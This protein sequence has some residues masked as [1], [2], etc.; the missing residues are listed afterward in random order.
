MKRIKGKTSRLK[1][2]FSEEIW[3]ME[4][5]ELSKAKARFIKYVKVAI[6]TAKTYAQQKIGPQ[7]VALSYL[8]VMALVPFLAIVFAITGGL[9]FDGLLKDFMYENF[10]SNQ[11][12]IDTVLSFSQNIIDTAQSGWMGF[13]NALLFLWIIY[14]LMAGVESA[15]N[16]VWKVNSNRSLV[17][18]LSYYLLILILSPFVILVLFSG[19]FVYT[20]LL[21]Y[22]GL[23]II[24][25]SFI[26][27]VISWLLFIVVAALTFSAMYK[28]I[29]KF[30]VKYGVAFRAAVFAAVAF[31]GMQ[32][33]YL[34]TQLL[35][36]RLNGVY[37]TFA[38]I[39]L[40]MV[41]LNISWNI[42]LMGAELSYAFQHVD[43]YNL[44]D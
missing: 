36:T 5:E 28:F 44:E 34:E 30:N 9:G 37:G 42:I 22:M 33:L 29:P 25:F 39:P 31:T 6:I 38:A 26:K 21:D 14:R 3:E 43:T 24:E 32:F 35:V 11:G 27:K 1:N 13:F 2:F 16:N 4:L 20:N 18:R 15:F 41:W 17:R 7:A 40:F 19:S 23:N 8:S 12:V 10:S